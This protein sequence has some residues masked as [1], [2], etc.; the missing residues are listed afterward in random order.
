MSSRENCNR[1]NTRIE[2]ALAFLVISLLLFS[3]IPL[4]ENSNPLPSGND[5]KSESSIRVLGG[6]ENMTVVFH[7]HDDGTLSKNDDTDFMNSD[8]PYNP[9]EIDYDQDNEIGLTFKK[10]NSG[11]PPH[12][13]QYFILEPQISGSIHITG[14]GNFSFWGSSSVNDTRMDLVATLYD[15]EDLAPGADIVISTV[16]MFEDPFSDKWIYYSI[17]F[18]SLDYVLPEN[19]TII[20]ELRRGDNNNI[21]FYL[22]YDQSSYDS[23]LELTISRHIDITDYGSEGLDGISKAEFG[24]QETIWVY[25]NISNAIGINDTQQAKVDVVNLSSMETIVSS[26]M[27]IYE[28]D[29]GPLP[30]WKLYRE[31]IGTL[32]NGTYDINISAV[33][34]SNNTVWVN[35]SIWVVSVDHFNVTARARIQAGESFNL[36]IE[37]LDSGNSRM[38]NWSGN[39]TIDAIDVVTSNITSEFLNITSI[40]MSS[41][42]NGIV[43]LLNESFMKAPMTILI[44]VSCDN[45]SGES[46]SIDTVPGEISSLELDPAN[47]SLSAGM[48]TVVTAIGKDNL[49]NINNSWVPY[50]NLSAP[51]AVISG[52]GTSINLTASIAGTANLTCQ[53]NGT[54][55]FVQANV[56]VTASDLSIIIVTPEDITVWEG[57]STDIS[58]EGFDAFE[59]PVNIT[60]A[61]WSLDGFTRSQVIG[62]GQNGL[63]SAG[64]QPESGSVRVTMGDISGTADIDVIVPPFGPSLGVLPNLVGSED[65]PLPSLDLSLYWNDPNGTH[66]LIWFVTD[67]NNSLITVLSD[68]QKRSVVHIIPQPNTF[69]DT[70]G[71]EVTFWVQDPDGYMN[72]RE[73]LI[74]IL[75]VNDPPMFIND[76]PNEIYVKFDLPYTF[77]YDYYISDVDDNNSE[78]ILMATPSDYVEAEGL[79]MTFEFPDLYNGEYYFE[80]LTLS[81]SDGH[82]SDSL[83]IKVWATTD[84][85]PELVE[86]LP[87][88]TINEGEMNV[89]IFDLDNYFTDIDG[90][91]LY[92]TEGFEYV[93][94]EIILGT[95]VV[96]LSSSSEWSGQ[97]NAVFIAHDP[98][99]AIRTD[100]ITITVNPVNDQP[101]IASIPPIKVHYNNLYQ[102]DLRPFVTDPD[103]AFEELIITTSDPNASYSFISFPQLKLLFPA[104]SSGGD[105][106]IGPYDI[107]ILLSVTDNGGLNDLEYFSV[108]VTDN[109]PPS[110][111]VSPPNLALSFSEDENLTRPQ[112]IRLP[113]LFTDSDGDELAFSFSGNNS[114]SITIDADGWVAFSSKIDWHGTEFITF[115]ATDP[116]EAWASL[117]VRLDV[118]SVNDPPT[119]EQIPD[120]NHLST[121]QWSMSIERYVDD[122]E[123]NSSELEIII[124]ESSEYVKAVGLTLYFDFPEN[125]NSAMVILYII[126]PDGS[127]SEIVEFKVEIRKTIAELIGYP[128]SFPVILLLAGILGYVLARRIPM[129]HELQDL[130]ITHNDGRLISHVGRTDDNGLDRDVVSAMFTAVQEF[131]KDSFREEPGGLKMLEIG[132]KKVIIE[133]GRWIYG[134][135]IYT[136]WPPKVLFKTFGKFI[137]D[138]EAKYGRNIEK[139]DGR[140]KSLPGIRE[141]SQEM[142]QN[143]YLSGI[144]E[145]AED[146]MPKKPVIS[147][148][149][150]VDL[151]DSE[152]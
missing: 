121:R 132:D 113:T 55:L 112:S 68:H 6:P 100:T 47:I 23:I 149:E 34:K 83:T 66:D 110:V 11:V 122:V 64:M 116:S 115:V 61:V 102:L 52:N 22:F 54:G 27:S 108:T 126:D 70:P 8:D 86:P 46:E 65:N 95:N 9:L 26:N 38:I 77:D 58:A 111:T 129:P 4:I 93:E 109:M 128:W 57:R 72:Y 74:T 101:E 59:N 60:T 89:E 138:I 44:R 140:L 146:K 3:A 33:D 53:D 106:Y 39:I 67:V 31:S 19:H 5:N 56:T 148:E 35:W 96:L 81:V 36:T 99:G 103:D 97:T 104:N 48:T 50:W 117:M 28:V 88:V 94:I 84:T 145:I 37:A 85:P 41:S 144:Y 143:R 139:W 130:F 127:D 92:Y 80:I 16:S 45:A 73:I 76:P 90:D 15:S 78:L 118:I 135:M 150:V 98:T 12:K 30:S 125:I 142:M 91:V 7:L 40:F 75:P 14:D 1:N 151:I 42:D 114:I 69:N 123:S 87:D 124:I 32:P 43:S 10:N 137:E 105:V 120:V 2:L 18:P 51:I 62:L 136:G 131:I 134:S 141:M 63:F 119:L 79:L 29:P 152:S 107:E 20:L 21:E 147:D 49:S 71:D 133:K 25:A 24:D 13:R 82:L 17:I